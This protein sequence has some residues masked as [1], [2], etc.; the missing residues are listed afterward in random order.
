MSLRTVFELNKRYGFTSSSL[1]CRRPIKEGVYH[2]IETAAE[3]QG[4]RWR[5]FERRIQAR[6]PGQSNF[7]TSP[8]IQIMVT[9]GAINKFGDEQQAQRK[10][11]DAA[12]REKSKNMISPER[13]AGRSRSI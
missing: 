12:R 6:R 2:T 11:D 1:S 9:T 7:A 10:A 8:Q 4:L 5:A 13:R 3:P